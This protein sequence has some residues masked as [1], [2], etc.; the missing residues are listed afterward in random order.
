[1]KQLPQTVVSFLEKQGFVIVS[2]LDS[3]GGIHSVAKGIADIEKEGRLYLVDLFRG[4][5]YANLKKNRAMSITAV[6][7]HLYRGYTLKGKGYIKEDE[8]IKEALL[9][10]W[11]ERLLHRI[12]KRMIR[13]IQQEKNIA[14]HH[15]AHL[16][17]PQYLIQMDVEEIVD[18]APFK[19][20]R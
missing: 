9:E 13:H 18:L 19:G 14:H 5:T 20:K 7:E 17:A 4:R 15:E 1:M 6:D 10:K 11:E 12:S 8:T 16:P 3:V 2:T